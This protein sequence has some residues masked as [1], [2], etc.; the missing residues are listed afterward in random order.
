MLR[1][2]N[3]SKNNIKLIEGYKNALSSMPESLMEA[4]E[5]VKRKYEGLEKSLD[6]QA[7]SI[8]DSSATSVVDDNVLFYEVLYRLK[9][10]SDI[11]SCKKAA[12][13]HAKVLAR[14]H[15]SVRVALCLVRLFV[16]MVMN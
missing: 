16:I 15:N 4:K 3:I 14:E 9:L 2:E 5:C 1:G 7:S 6:I 10:S 12:V 11:E 8:P 13:M